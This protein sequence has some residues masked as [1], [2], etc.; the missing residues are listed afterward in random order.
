MPNAAANVAPI[1]DPNIN[2]LAILIPA[3]MCQ[4]E[5]FG[6]FSIQS[7]A[8]QHASQCAQLLLTYKT[9]LFLHTFI[10]THNHEKQRRWHREV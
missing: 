7:C 5:R 9:Y 2:L 4:I 10:Y 3:Y 1:D 6:T 8:E